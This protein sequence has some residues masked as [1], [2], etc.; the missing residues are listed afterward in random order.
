MFESCY[1]DDVK[2]YETPTEYDWQDGL[3]WHDRFGL[4][5]KK[6]VPARDWVAV[7]VTCKPDHF[8]FRTVLD[9]SVLIWLLN[10]IDAKIHSDDVDL[11]TDA[12]VQKLLA[13]G[14]SRDN[15]RMPG[16]AKHL[17]IYV[18]DD[19]DEPLDEFSEYM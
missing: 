6:P 2:E 3:T 8:S 15:I 7:P 12:I 16:S 1:F 5:M 13:Q 11:Q 4:C 14:V 19:F 9:T 18:A 10:G 17:D